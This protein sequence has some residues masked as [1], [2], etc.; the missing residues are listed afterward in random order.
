MNKQ[1]LCYFATVFLF[2]LLGCSN[3]DILEQDLEPQKIETKA[4]GECTGFGGC[5]PKVSIREIMS[6]VVTI[7]W[8]ANPSSSCKKFRIYYDG[9]SDFGFVGPTD[10]RTINNS[11][12]STIHF[13]IR[14]EEDGCEYCTNSIEYVIPN[15]EVAPQGCPNQISYGRYRIEK[16]NDTYLLLVKIS[17]LHDLNAYEI[18]TKYP[19][20][21][22]E[23]SPHSMFS[24]NF[25]STA[26]IP[27]FLKYS[28][29]G[30]TQIRC[31]YYYGGQNENENHY[32]YA[33]GLGPL[34][35]M[36]HGEDRMP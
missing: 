23:R 6:G 24:F 13:S 21:R 1:F 34:R 18:V 27:N 20:G 5:L 30:T 28:G 16:Y 35:E 3:E 10:S 33:T 2:T 32:L 25:G 29:E 26:Y 8:S 9:M 7:S 19:D 17:P 22:V 4:L 36:Y 11:P 12:G 14:C 31:Y 15:G